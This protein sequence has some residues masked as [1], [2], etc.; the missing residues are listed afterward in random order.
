MNNFSSGLYF[1][2]QN[3]LKDWEKFVNGWEKESF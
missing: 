3:A 1:K 2:T